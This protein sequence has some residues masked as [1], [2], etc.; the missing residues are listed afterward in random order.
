M[1][2]GIICRQ[3]WD[4]LADICRLGSFVTKWMH[5]PRMCTALVW[6]AFTHF[7]SSSKAN[8]LWG[9]HWSGLSGGIWGAA[10]PNSAGGI[11]AI[12]VNGWLLTLWARLRYFLFG[13][14]REI[15]VL[16][17]LNLRATLIIHGWTMP[18]LNFTGSMWKLVLGS[19]LVSA[20]I[21]VLGKSPRPL[22]CT[23]KHFFQPTSKA[24]YV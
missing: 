12:L 21:F 16:D 15:T 2:N 23:E 8:R 19:L 6:A 18:P 17:W 7:Q 1:L 5:S 20:L 14:C 10:A 13:S 4:L 22:L 9:P 11:C 3:I 24:G